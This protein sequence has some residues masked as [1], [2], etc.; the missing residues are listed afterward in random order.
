[1]D[2]FTSFSA[3]CTLSMLLTRSVTYTSKRNRRV[4]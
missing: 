1:L 2:G 3:C 4:S